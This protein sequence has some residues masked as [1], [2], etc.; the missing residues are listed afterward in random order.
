MSKLVELTPNA[1]QKLKVSNNAAALVAKQM[2]IINITAAEV[3]SAATDLPVFF[4]RNAQSGGWGMCVLASLEQGAAPLVANDR[5]LGLYTPNFLKS[6][7][8]FPI[9][10]PENNSYSLGIDPE[11]PALL[12]NEGEALFEAD[13][14]ET[15]FLDNVRR[16]I[17]ADIKAGYQTWLMTQ[18]LEKLGLFKSID[19][20][21]QYA[22]GSQQKLHGLFTINEEKLQ[23]IDKENLVVMHQKG[24]LLVLHAALM[25]IY[26]LN[27]LIRLHSEHPGKDKIV[28]VKISDADAKS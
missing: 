22:D 7:P 16:T 15:L 2:Q 8:I 14:K 18:E 20:V 21:L 17:D 26:Q 19:L 12:Q 11:N 27:R 25:S 28:N 3:A 1:H 4:T 10:N 23:T 9:Q 6:Y 24:Y 13:G 5:W